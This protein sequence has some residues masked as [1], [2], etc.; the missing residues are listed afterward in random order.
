[1]ASTQVR[2]VQLA[3]D[4]QRRTELGG[5]VGQ[6]A[7]I[8]YLPVLPHPGFTP[9]HLDRA[10]QDRFS[11]S[12]WAADRVHTEM[13]AIDEIDVSSAGRSVHAAVSLRLPGVA[14]AGRIIGQIS[15]GFDNRAPARV[16]GRVANQK[17][18]HQPRRG[19][20]R[21]RFVEGTGQRHLHLMST[22][23]RPNKRFGAPPTTKAANARTVPT[24]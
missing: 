10:N 5:A 12:A 16:L 1:M 9:G 11:A 15:L 4:V 8:A 18:P 17:R 20:P 23:S 24:L 22:T 6:L 7:G 14:V 2:S 19:Q 21:G 13:V 3:V